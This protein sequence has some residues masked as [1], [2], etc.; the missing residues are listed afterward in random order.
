MMF[1]KDLYGVQA[2]TYIGLGEQGRRVRAIGLKGDSLPSPLVALVVLL[3]LSYFV[4]H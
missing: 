2:L 1:E 4:K 3:H